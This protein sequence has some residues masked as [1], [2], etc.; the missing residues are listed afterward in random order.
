MIGWG[1]EGGLAGGWVCWWA[2]LR[3]WAALT[4]AP[5]A[6]A[7]DASATATLPARRRT[8][9]A[10]LPPPPNIFKISSDYDSMSWAGCDGTVG[11]PPGTGRFLAAAEGA[12]ASV[13]HCYRRPC[14]VTASLRLPQCLITR[15]LLVI[16]FSA[17][18][19]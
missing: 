10:P 14:S 19:Y 6:G 16:E 4:P 17:H 15:R 11:A 8:G 5:P 7:T 18:S 1:A 3:G 12:A 13:L 2:R 9:P